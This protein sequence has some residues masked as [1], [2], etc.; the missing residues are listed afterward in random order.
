[1]TV[2]PPLLK[3]DGTI[4]IVAPSRWPEPAWIKTGRTL[5][6]KRGYKV[7]VHPQC[8]LKKGELAGGDQQRADALM[9]MFTDRTIDAIICARGGTGANRMVDLLDFK[10]IK[11]NPKPLVGFSDV[12][13]L[14]N[15]ITQKCGSVTY[16]GPMIVSLA[17]NNIATNLDDLLVVIGEGKA[18]HSLDYPDAI[19]T[20]TGKVS[21][22]LVGG[23]LTLL[24][25]L[26]A[27]D[28]E[29]SAKGGILFIE[30]IDEPL[31]KIDRV[32]QQLRLAGK[33]KGLR[34]LIVGDFLGL[35]ATENGFAFGKL[36]NAKN[37]YGLNLVEIMQNVVPDVPVCFNF[38]CG[39]G[40]N[41]TTLPL[42][43]KV[44]ANFTKRGV[45]IA[46]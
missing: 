8:S 42:G 21:G 46:F 43:A 39:H 35:S 36:V 22:S 25:S 29:W 10:T 33:L 44:K 19:C 41:L 26:L 12:T 4:G 38:P 15:A 7:V 24:Q 32:M 28:Y 11:K 14:L 27:T 40:K 34:G 2:F 6:E 16:H 17:K 13:V 31:Y 45:N 18:K 30:D 20:R 23:N 9:D 3:Q 37:T 1:M 5:L